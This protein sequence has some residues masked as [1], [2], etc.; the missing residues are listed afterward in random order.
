[1]CA[2][3]NK[4]SD[5]LSVCNNRITLFTKIKRFEKL[6]FQILVASSPFLIGDENISAY[7]DTQGGN[8]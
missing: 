2:R 1:M 3:V 4:K 7:H 6:N 5:E 8:V